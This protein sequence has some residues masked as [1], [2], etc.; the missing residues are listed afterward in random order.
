MRDEVREADGL[1]GLERSE[2]GVHDHVQ[3]G[4]RDGRDPT[5]LMLSEYHSLKDRGRHMSVKL[6]VHKESRKT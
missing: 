1:A 3:D 2:V 5:R 6:K 4:S